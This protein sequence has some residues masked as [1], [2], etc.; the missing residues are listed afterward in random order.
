[1]INENKIKILFIS[2]SYPRFKGDMAGKFF[3]PLVEKLNETYCV[4]VLAPDDICVDFDNKTF[5]PFQYFPVKSWQKLT[6]SDGIPENIS[7]KPLTIFLFPFLLITMIFK[8]FAMASNYDVIITNWLLPS[9]LAGAIVSKLTKK[10]HILI[11]H[12]AGVHYLLKLPFKKQLFNFIFKYTDKLIFVSPYLQEKLSDLISDKNKVDIIP[13][14]INLDLFKPA[15]DINEIKR[16]Y[17][18]SLNNKLVLYM[19][20][21]V[22]IK[23]L[24]L[25]IKAL[26]GIEN[27][28]LLIAGDGTNIE[29]YKNLARVN[30]VNAIFLGPIDD[31]DKINILNISDIV[32]VPSIEL[33]N[34]RTEGTPVVIIEAMA[35]GKVILASNVG[36]IPY[37]IENNKNGLLFNSTNF[38][39]IREGLK[40]IF[41]N[42]DLYCKL[43][44]EAKI[45]A[46]KYDINSVSKKYIEIIDK[47]KQH[48]QL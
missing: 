15:E 34:S 2:T 38:N 13:M 35:A 23:G 39:E 8:I 16:K 20:R 10:P 6:Y 28:T 25:L 14:G 21:L 17:N 45:S 7:Q 5:K 27:T 47:V 31:E 19:G 22:Q 43:A 24:E 36:G 12:S 11:E 3:I 40:H 42:E 18:I 44:N 30:N 48:E 29:N 33:K 32:V 46:Q 1:M 4:D 37:I 41:H 9:G 26:S